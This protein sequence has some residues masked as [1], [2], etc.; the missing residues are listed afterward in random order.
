KEDIL[1][2]SDKEDILEI[3]DKEDILEVSDKEDM[4]EASD[5]DTPE[6]EVQEVLELPV[7][8]MEM[9]TLE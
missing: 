3:S 1:E 6:L 5:K 4:L 9:L 2:V 7:W 8:D